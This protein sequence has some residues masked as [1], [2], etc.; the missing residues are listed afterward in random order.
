MAN[1]SRSRVMMEKRGSRRASAGESFS[2]VGVSL[3]L[4]STQVG[5]QM[6]TCEASPHGVWVV[7]PLG[8]G[9][10]EP[11]HC[12]LLG[13]YTKYGPGPRITQRHSESLQAWLHHTPQLGSS[14]SN[15]ARDRMDSLR[16]LQAQDGQWGE[17]VG[18]L[19]LGLAF[20]WVS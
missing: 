16:T 9:S 6:G 10:G 18:Q 8:H 3:R 11:L 7:K 4:C 5:S 2:L 20:W 13:G 15:C 12:I 19:G 14:L 1:P 17:S